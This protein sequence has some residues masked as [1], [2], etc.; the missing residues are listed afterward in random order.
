MHSPLNLNQQKNLDHWLQQLN[1]D[2]LQECTYDGELTFWKT[3]EANKADRRKSYYK[4]DTTIYKGNAGIIL[5]LLA[6][7]YHNQEE[8]YLNLAVT[9]TEWL[10]KQVNRDL[11]SHTALYT[12]KSGLIYVL[13][14]MY[15]I[16]KEEKYRKHAISFLYKN[17][18]YFKDHYSD[19][20][21][22]GNAGNLLVLDKA[23]QASGE[24]WI[25]D[26]FLECVNDLIDNTFLSN[27]GIKWRYRPNF[28]DSLCGFSHGAAGIGFVLLELANAHQ[29]SGLSWLGEQAYQYES[30]HYSKDFKTWPDF[31]IH[32]KK[33]E[34]PDLVSNVDDLMRGEEVNGWAHG[35][36]GIAM[37]RLRA[38]VLTHK[39]EYKKEALNVIEHAVRK[40]SDKKTANFTVTNGHASLSYLLAYGRGRFKQ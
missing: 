6:V 7:H 4:A 36:L 23:Y 26:L 34:Q 32:P 29:S 8:V 15:E 40:Y 12:G 27:Q 21:L 25:K 24:L 18:R 10:I 39:S 30:Q 5:Y 3:L 17:K 19:D 13:A 1:E 11:N 28:I 38:H 31:R 20:L 37:T 14:C 33:L 16:T 2:L 9:T 35:G 22:S